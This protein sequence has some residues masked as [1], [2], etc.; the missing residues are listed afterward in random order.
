[1]RS[2]VSDEYPQEP[3]YGAVVSAGHADGG[4]FLFLRPN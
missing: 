4:D 3:Q 2:G 1:V